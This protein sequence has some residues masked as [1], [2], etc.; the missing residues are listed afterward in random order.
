MIEAIQTRY[1]GHHFRSRL[2]ARWAVFFNALGIEYLYEPEAFP[3]QDP[4]GFCGEWAY[5]PD[6]Y[7]PESDVWVEV[8]GALENATDEY[9]RMILSAVESSSLPGNSGNLLWL[10]DVPR[11]SGRVH[12]VVQRGKGG[13]IGS[14][15]FTDKPGLFVWNPCDSYIHKIYPG[16]FKPVRKGLREMLSNEVYDD[17]YPSYV[18]QEA[19]DAARSARFSYVR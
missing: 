16:R 9:L 13:V 15:V 12:P 3:V 6:F 5:L 1:A 17:E 4:A 19:L 2:E 10:G 18:V 8:K 11:W 7:L 14:A